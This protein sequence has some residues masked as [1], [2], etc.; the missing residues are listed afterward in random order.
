MNPIRYSYIL[1]SHIMKQVIF[2]EI[3]TERAVVSNGNIL[4]FK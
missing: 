4:K 1:H 3:Y 2:Y